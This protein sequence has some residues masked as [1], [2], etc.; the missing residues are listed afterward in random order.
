[1]GKEGR[2]EGG[3]HLAAFIFIFFWHFEKVDK[4]SGSWR[5]QKLMGL[6]LVGSRSEGRISGGREGK[7]G[8]REVSVVR[9]H[10]MRDLSRPAPTQSEHIS[11][12]R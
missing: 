2:R 4:G 7:G 12:G 3:A 5:E 6:A 1:M 11:V 9:P 8:E 10:F